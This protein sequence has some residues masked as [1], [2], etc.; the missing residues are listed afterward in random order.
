MSIVDDV[1]RAMCSKHG[2]WDTRTCPVCANHEAAQKLNEKASGEREMAHELL[3]DYTR[4]YFRLSLKELLRHD[5]TPFAE[6]AKITPADIVARA[7]TYAQMAAGAML[8]N[9]YPKLAE[10]IRKEA[11]ADAES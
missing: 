9:Q 8:A 11:Q 2:Y 6:R 10:I 3:G 7:M 4:E 1:Y 5:L